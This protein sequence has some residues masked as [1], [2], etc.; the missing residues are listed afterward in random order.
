MLAVGMQACQAHRRLMEDDAEEA[1]AAPPPATLAPAPAPAASAAFEGA[2]LGAAIPAPCAVPDG[3]TD[4]QSS[5]RTLEAEDAATAEQPPKKE[6]EDA[7]E[8]PRKPS[9]NPNRYDPQTSYTADA[10]LTLRD[11]SKATVG[12]APTATGACARHRAGWPCGAEGSR[13][14]CNGGW[15][16]LCPSGCSLSLPPWRLN[17]P[18][19]A[20][21]KQQKPAAKDK[22]TCNALDRPTR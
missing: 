22:G 16:W 9:Q 19:P 14:A 12:P 5:G 8:E 13:Q 7:Q 1:A 3:L 20:G 21:F 2:A 6:E 18:R 10:E 17:A 11:G 4:L 15:E